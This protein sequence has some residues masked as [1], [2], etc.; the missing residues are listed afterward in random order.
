MSLQIHNQLIATDVDGYLAN[1]Q[2]WNKDIA[3]QIALQEKL[4]LTA[5]HWLVINFL[6]D[7]YLTYK[8]MPAMRVLVKELAKQLDKE[9]ANSA[10]LSSLFPEGLMKQASKIAGLPKPVRC[11]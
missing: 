2:A 3:K 1:L 9:K 7:F 8:I 6:R 4:T 5:D 11:I 10:Y